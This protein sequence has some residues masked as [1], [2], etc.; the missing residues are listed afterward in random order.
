MFT[1]WSTDK[2]GDLA[3]PQ[4]GRPHQNA[5]VKRFNPF[6]HDEQFRA[7]LFTN[8]NQGQEISAA[9]MITYNE[10]RPN[11]S[12]RRISPEEFCRPII[13]EMSTFSLSA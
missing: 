6:F 5:Y 8:L 10:K 4:P 9:W 1:D 2:S 7:Y 13:G 3:Y 12:L 11:D